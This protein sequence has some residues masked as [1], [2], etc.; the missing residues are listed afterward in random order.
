M[1]HQPQVHIVVTILCILYF[2]KSCATLAKSKY[3]LMK[4]ATLPEA[5]EPDNSFSGTFE[6]TM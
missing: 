2:I 1:G 5:I 4:L 6:Y 3:K